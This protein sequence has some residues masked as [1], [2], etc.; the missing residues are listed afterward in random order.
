M[1]NS[2]VKLVFERGAPG[3]GGEISKPAGAE[4]VLKVLEGVKIIDTAEVP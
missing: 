2:G 1:F 4:N 3:Y